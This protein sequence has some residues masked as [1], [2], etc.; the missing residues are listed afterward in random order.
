MAQHIEPC[1]KCGAEVRRSMGFNESEDVR[2]AEYECDC[3]LS[4]YAE[5]RI[6]AGNRHDEAAEIAELEAA[7]N[8]RAAVAPEQKS[9]TT[10]ALNLVRA[11]YDDT[12]SFDNAAREL[13]LHFD[14]EGSE[15]LAA[16]VI[17]Q[18]GGE[19]TFSTMEVDPIDKVALDMFVELHVLLGGSKSELAQDYFARLR[20]FM[21][22]T[23]IFQ[24][25]EARLRE[26]PC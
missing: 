4:F 8:T 23:R 10:L 25:V 15:D 17:A 9:L 12:L 18:R 5:S 21:P 11:H 2:W 19:G 24:A 26:S 14:A 22:K 20:Q 3:G 13:A 16:Y 1:P 7:W 6:Y